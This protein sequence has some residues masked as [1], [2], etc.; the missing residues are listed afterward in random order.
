MIK[1]YVDWINESAKTINWVAFATRVS[2][3]LKSGNLN[4]SFSEEDYHIIEYELSDEWN[5]K[6]QEQTHQIGKRESFKEISSAPPKIWVVGEIAK[7]LG[8][9]VKMCDMGCGLGLVVLFSKRMGLDAM[10]VEWQKRLKPVH[11]DLGIKVVYG[12]FFTM[13][14]G[15]LEKQD[16]VYLYQPVKTTF[17]SLKLL[18]LISN[19]TKSDVVILYNGMWQGILDKLQDDSRFELYPLSM[20]PNGSYL[21]L[22]VKKNEADGYVE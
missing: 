2:K 22:I 1:K 6:P 18:D 11:D 20:D 5:K 15:F 8:G 4:Y 17:N 9:K 3:A 19:N 14:L 7:V 16:I 10:G 13:N 12:D 21:V